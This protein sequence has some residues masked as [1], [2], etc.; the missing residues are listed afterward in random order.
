MGKSFTCVPPAPSA[1]MS[2]FSPSWAWEGGWGWRAGSDGSDGSGG[3]SSPTRPSWGCGAGPG[4]VE[5]AGAAGAEGASWSEQCQG[6]VA[7]LNDA[8]STFEVLC[9]RERWGAGPTTRGLRTGLGRVGQGAPPGRGRGRRASSLCL[10][11]H[12]ALAPAWAHCGDSN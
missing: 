3:G 11:S 4:R 2:N 1:P 8:P 7:R 9:V 10:S 5:N 6:L 12:A